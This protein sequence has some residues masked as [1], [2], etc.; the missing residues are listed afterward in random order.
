MRIILSMMIA[1]WTMIAM[2]DMPERSPLTVNYNDREGGGLISGTDIGRFQDGEPNVIIVPDGTDDSVVCR[3]RSASGNCYRL[4]VTDGQGHVPVPL[5][6]RETFD[7]WSAA[8][9]TRENWSICEIIEE[10]WGPWELVGEIPTEPGWHTLTEE[11]Q[12]STGEVAEACPDTCPEATQSRT[13]DIYNDEPEPPACTDTFWSPDPWGYYE[14]QQFVQTSNCGNTQTVWGA[15]PAPAEEPEVCTPEV[16]LGGINPDD[17][18]VDQCAEFSDGCGGLVEVCG[19]MEYE[20][21]EPP[22]PPDPEPDEPP[23]VPTPGTYSGV[24]DFAYVLPS[25]EFEGDFQVWVSGSNYDE[26]M[27]AANDAVNYYT[28]YGPVVTGMTDESV[29]GTTCP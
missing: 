26:L 17:Y 10:P 20:V 15:F 13:T 11:R 4:S 2:A 12:C 1:G 22:Q 5:I 21:V 18:Y 25:G 23:C 16:D 3:Y 7:N 14:N 8:F 29:P 19:T 27:S 9:R 24:I 28:Q 6:D